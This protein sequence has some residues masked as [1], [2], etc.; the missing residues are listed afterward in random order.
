MVSNLLGTLKGEYSI[1]K[2]LSEGT[3][4]NGFRFCLEE[5]TVEL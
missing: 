5:V 4:K 1:L 2:A 3:K